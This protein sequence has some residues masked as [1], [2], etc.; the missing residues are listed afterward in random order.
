MRGVWRLM[1]GSGGAFKAAE[2]MSTFK[3]TK[4]NND[5]KIVMETKYYN[6]KITV[7]RLN[8]I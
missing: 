4:V 8:N 6:K 3:G 2:K 5:E 1:S 7:R